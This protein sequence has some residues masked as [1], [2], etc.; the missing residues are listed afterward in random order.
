MRKPKK[1]KTTTT[2]TTS[3]STTSHTNT[4][5][6]NYREPANTSTDDGLSR[7]K[8]RVA[9][10]PDSPPEFTISKRSTRPGTQDEGRARARARASPN[11]DVSPELPPQ[12]TKIA[13]PMSD[14]PIINRN[15]EMRKAG[16]SSNRRSS[17]GKR[18]RRA[19]SLIDSG[20]AALPH[21]DVSA[22]DFYKLISASEELPEPR[23]MKQ[24]L[25]WCAQR[26]LPEKPNHNTPNANV[27]L[28]ARAIQVLVSQDLSS[29][30][31]CTNWYN[32][33]ENAPKTRFLKPNPKNLE[34]DAKVAALQGRIKRYGH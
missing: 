20:Q 3:T 14:T 29:R 25:T 15:K 22:A 21:P 12:G 33:D 9:E 17:L 7:R 19:S 31:D 34:L 27:I 23:R 11:R 18:G 5:A 6:D 28:G 26:A 1:P 16:G 10:I 8:P 2:T 24:L 32:R 13:L 4:T 30:P